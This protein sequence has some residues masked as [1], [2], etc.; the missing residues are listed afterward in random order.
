[1]AD[2]E[3]TAD[4]RHELAALLDDAQRLRVE[5]P[6]VA[7]YLDM[8]PGLS[9]TGDP[10]MDS[11]F[12]LRFI[13]YMTN[14]DSFS[15]NP[16]WDIVEPLVFEH[17]SRRVVS[18]GRPDGSSRLAYAEIILQATYAYAIPS[19]EALEWAAGFC[20]DRPVVELGAGRGYW[21]AQLARQGLRV[22]AYDVEP[23]D[24]A[25]NVS[26][27]R[28]AGQKDVWHPVG[29]LDA[30]R[31]RVRGDPDY[32]LFLCWPPGWGSPMASQALATFQEAG[33]ERV[34][35]IGEP[36]GG[37]TGDAAF[38]EALDAGWALGSQCGQHVSWWNLNDI[39]QAWVRR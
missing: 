8:A 17:G 24:T 28:A 30:Y 21:A 10:E 3:I 37:K 2:L 20:G 29:D 14:G 38:F 9:G 36:K 35:F 5:F 27:L 16:Y 18:G 12:D 7:E 11:V 22:D 25:E 23:P 19:P 4:R 34:L 31:D 26:F 6:K 39:A 13:H 32:V 1:M 15:A 33:G